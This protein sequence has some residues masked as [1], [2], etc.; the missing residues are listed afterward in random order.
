MTS[1]GDIVGRGGAT[2]APHF[3]EEMRHVSMRI[4]GIRYVAQTT[5]VPF[6]G[7]ETPPQH[8]PDR[9]HDRADQETDQDSTQCHPRSICVTR[10]GTIVTKF[11]MDENMFP[12]KNFQ[13]LGIYE[14]LH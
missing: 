10:K 1:H 13:L 8:T 3:L 2:Q 6:G 14:Y 11:L 7:H 9:A 12:L 4:F 5:S